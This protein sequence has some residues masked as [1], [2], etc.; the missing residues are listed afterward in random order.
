MQGRHISLI[1]NQQWMSDR[2]TT[3]GSGGNQGSP[4]GEAGGIMS[5][6]PGENPDF[7]NWNVAY[8]VYCSSDGWTGTREASPGSGNIHFAGHYIATAMIDAL[9]S[10]DIIGSPNLSDATHVIL[11]GSS[12]G[13]QGLR[14]NVDRLAEM[15]EFADV[16]AISDAGVFFVGIPEFE[17]VFE[18]TTQAQYRAWEAV[19]DEDCIADHPDDPWTCLNGGVLV[20][21][22]YIQTPMFIHQ[23]QE[24]VKLK[25]ALQATGFDLEMY[26]PAIGE[27]TRPLLEQQDGVYSPIQGRHIILNTN[28]FSRFRFAG[29]TMAEVFGNWYFDRDGPTVSIQYP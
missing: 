25:E 17:A 27:A 4:D 29:H 12:A 19:L 2:Y 21:E 26:L 18:E 16:R 3:L 1:S 24:D 14:S 22:G 20:D 15:L 6:I 13:A 23:D 5:S 11:S 9:M 8:L 10:E 7:Y 28:R